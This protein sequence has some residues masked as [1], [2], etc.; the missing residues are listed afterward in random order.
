MRSHHVTVDVEEVFHSTLLAERVPEHQWADL[1]RRAPGIVSWLLDEMA[2]RDA[3]GTFFILGWLAAKEPEMVRRISDAGHEVAAHSW[4]HRPVSALGH[5]GFRATVR[6]SKDLLEQIVG[7]PVLGFRAPSFS[8]LPGCEWALDVL[9]EEGYG[10]DS[11]LF[12]IRVHPQYGYPDGESD[13][14][15]IERPGTRL[16]EVPPLT[17]RFL[18]RRLPAAGGAYLRF[19]PLRLFRTALR[20]AERR[21]A[22]GTLYVHPWDLDPDLPRMRLGARDALRLYGGSHRARRR[23]LRLL[24]EFRSVP[25]VETMRRM[26]GVGSP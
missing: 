19:F 25:V 13:P 7:S 16:L 26:N 5:E 11:S 23:L 4:A 22:P 21:G 14:Y 8:I 9:E 1:P 17:L 6:R 10:Y 24:E 20:Q 18:G 15:W 3:R 12:P 2:A